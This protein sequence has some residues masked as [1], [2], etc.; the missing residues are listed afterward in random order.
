MFSNILAAFLVNPKTIHDPTTNWEFWKFQVPNR[1]RLF[2]WKGCNDPYALWSCSVTG[3]TCCR[4]CLCEACLKLPNLLFFDVTVYLPDLQSKL[5]L[6][7]CTTSWFLWN[8][9]N[10]TCLS[11]GNMCSSPDTLVR[12]VAN[13]AVHFL[14]LY[15]VFLFL[16]LGYI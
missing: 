2:L 3:E 12:K 9:R 8:H 11:L 14:E 5:E 15:K 13:F 1:I 16:I 6:L 10:E 7:V 4:S